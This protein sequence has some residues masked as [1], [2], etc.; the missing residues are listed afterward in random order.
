MTV[1]RRGLAEQKPNCLM[2]ER[3]KGE[4]RITLFKKIILDCKFG[5]KQDEILKTQTTYNALTHLMG[6]VIASAVISVQMKKN[7]CDIT[8][9]D[10]RR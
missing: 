7:L 6:A 2:N 1:V 8:G 3:R 10:S 4:V 5:E 9:K